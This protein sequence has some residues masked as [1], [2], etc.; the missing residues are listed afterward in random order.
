MC[1]FE[2]QTDFVSLQ[3]TRWVRNVQASRNKDTGCGPDLSAVQNGPTVWSE[4]ILPLSMRLCVAGGAFLLLLLGAFER[5]TT[6]W[7]LHGA[8]H[9]S[10]Y[11]AVANMDAD[12]AGGPVTDEEDVD[13]LDEQPLTDRL[14]FWSDYARGLCVVALYMVVVWQLEAT[15]HW[16][17]GSITPVLKHFRLV[18]S[19][20]AGILNSSWLQLTFRA[21]AT[22]AIISCARAPSPHRNANHDN[23]QLSLEIISGGCVTICASAISISFP[24]VVAL[25][26]AIVGS[27]LILLAPVA[28]HTQ[29]QVAGRNDRE[30]ATEVGLPNEGAPVASAWLGI[31]TLDSWSRTAG[32]VV[33]LSCIVVSSPWGF[34]ADLAPMSWI[35][36]PSGAW[37]LLMALVG[38]LGYLRI[39][40]FAQMVGIDHVVQAELT[41][42][43]AYI[44]SWPTMLNFFSI[45]VRGRGGNACCLP[46]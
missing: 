40:C 38:G 39:G 22:C 36:R 6:S 24:S 31:M 43:E 28:P 20:I 35:F 16:V 19:P 44:K 4:T 9:R 2:V 8:T 23:P 29:A 11:T 25:G 32:F 5:P 10:E 1:W 45:V 14:P 15:C 18:Q 41:P 37:L 30:N 13:D 34:F 21:V 26:S 12:A 3:L 42:R 7:T 27:A 33:M 46:S 17:D